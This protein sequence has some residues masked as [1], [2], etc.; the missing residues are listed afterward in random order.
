MTHFL[1]NEIYDRWALKSQWYKK[2]FWEN[3][4]GERVIRVGSGFCRS[5]RLWASPDLE[6]QWLWTV[7]CRCWEQSSEPLPEPR[8]LS[9]PGPPLQLHR[10]CS[11]SK[12]HLSYEEKRFPETELQRASQHVELSRYARKHQ[13]LYL[14]EAPRWGAPTAATGVEAF[15]W[16]KQELTSRRHFT[17][18]V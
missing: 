17:G 4:C 6:S 18:I 2:L 5:Q 9:S 16:G 12:R 3:V 1:K 13:I 8:V 10:V 11:I 15:C 7:R 14:P